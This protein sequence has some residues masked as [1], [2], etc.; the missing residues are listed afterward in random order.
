M[1]E[2]SAYAPGTFCWVEL[3]ASDQ[4]GA[5]SFYA[6]LFGWQA[7]DIP[8]GESGSA[9]S[10]MRLDGKDVAAIAPQP[11]QQRDA[12]APSMWNSYV[13]V[14]DADAAAARAGELGANVH[15]GAFDVFDA[16]RMAVLQDPQGA[17]VEVWQS[18]NH[19]G[20]QLVNGPGAFCWN[21]LMTPDLDAAAGF[22][23]ELFGWTFEPFPAS[24]L[25]YRLIKNGEAGNGGITVL[26]EE[27][28]QPG[29]LVYFGVEDVEQALAT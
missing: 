1:G 21:E 6:E 23:G 5:K 2:R 29:W 13:A 7:E 27:G 16:G 28:M 17:F 18:R 24:P 15:A 25:P 10:M 11:Q 3:T 4:P 14:Q 9:Y 22:Y 12:G 8:M 19:F 26:P 20:A